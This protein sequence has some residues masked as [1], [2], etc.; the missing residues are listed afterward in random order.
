MNGPGGLLTRRRGE[1]IA[2]E[3]AGISYPI[4]RT[5]F[6]DGRLAEIFVGCPN[7]GLV[8]PTAEYDG[9]VATRLV[10]GYG[11]PV[12]TVRFVFQKIHSSDIAGPLG[13]TLY[14]IEAPDGD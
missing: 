7:L 3:L 4:Q 10:L 8:A 14:S 5:R 6:E 11:C 12:D 1:V 2:L 9:A 13:K